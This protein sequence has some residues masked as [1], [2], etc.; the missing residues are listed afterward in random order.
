MN[1]PS[2]DHSFESAASKVTSLISVVICT[3]N[4]PADIVQAVGSIFADPCVTIELIVIDQS[5]DDA[6][7]L[8]LA[9]MRP[10]NLRYIKSTTTGKGAALNEAFAVAASPYIVCT[11]DDC[12]APPGWITSIVRPLIDRPD[13]ALV[14]SPVIAAPHDERFGYIPAYTMGRDRL[15]TKPRQ[16]CRGHGL[17]AGMAVRRDAV[18]AMGGADEALGPGARFPAAD[19]LDLEIRFLLRGSHVYEAADIGIVHYG[20]RTLEQ[21]RAHTVRDWTALGACLAKPLR[22]RHPVALLIAAWLVWAR[23]LRPAI[24]DVGHLRRPRLRRIA[25]FASGFAAG[26]RVPVERTTIVFQPDAT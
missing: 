15:L 23:A 25:A 4:R 9:D 13:V 5:D 3:R 26:L 14:F 20:F 21:G 22:A 10:A 1:S 7:E 16:I 24:V 17:G 12:V 18:L 6:T 8:A 2:L 19:D 11:D